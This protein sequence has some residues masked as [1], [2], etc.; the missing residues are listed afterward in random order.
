MLQTQES[1]TEHGLHDIEYGMSP[2]GARYIVHDSCGFQAGQQNEIDRV[3]SFLGVRLK[4]GDFAERLHAILYAPALTACMLDHRLTSFNRYCISS[5][6][7]RTTE[8]ADGEFFKALSSFDSSVPVIVV[9][10]R[11]DELEVLCGDDIEVK[12][13]EEHDLQSRRRLRAEDWDV[14]ETLTNAKVEEKKQVL[15]TD[16]ARHEFPFSGPVFTSKS[17]Q[18][19]SVIC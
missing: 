19:V 12:Y 11:L 6:R 16:F 10:T 2:E 18:I 8:S 4:S 3:K 5:T 1:Q 13:M 14:I 15:A 9:A 7:V 17:K